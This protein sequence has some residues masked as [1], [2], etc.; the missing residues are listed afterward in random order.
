MIILFKQKQK[1]DET[2]SSIRKMFIQMQ[3]MTVGLS[4]LR[5][6]YRIVYIFLF[7]HLK[8]TINHD[9]PKDGSEQSSVSLIL[10]KKII[11]GNNHNIIVIVVSVI[12]GSFSLTSLSNVPTRIN[13]L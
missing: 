9:V 10:L 5:H 3:M 4:S 7:F 1:M 8:P 12:K 6:S 2:S 13:F 11:I